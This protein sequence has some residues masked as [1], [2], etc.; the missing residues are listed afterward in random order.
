MCVCV[1][2]MYGASALV[3]RTCWTNTLGAGAH[4]AGGVFVTASREHRQGLKPLRTSTT[5]RS[6]SNISE[7]DGVAL[8]WRTT[9]SVSLNSKLTSQLHIFFL[10]LSRSV[11]RTCTLTQVASGVTLIEV[12]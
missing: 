8:Q 12:N 2:V 5:R 10:A 6:V 11:F 7:F 3:E 1:C 4:I 9:I